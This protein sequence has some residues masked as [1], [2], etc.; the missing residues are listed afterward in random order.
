M[1]DTQNLTGTIAAF[2]DN[3]DDARQAVE[4]LRDA[5][6]SSAHIGVA[7]R[8][9][10]GSRFTGTASTT[11]TSAGTR[12]KEKA[13]STWDKIKSWFSGDEPEPYENERPRGDLAGREVVDPDA[14]YGYGSSDLDGSFRSLDIPEER[15][16]YFSHRLGRGSDGAVVTVNAGTRRSEAEDIL[17]EYGGDLGA[18]ASTY[19]YGNTGYSGDIG[20]AG[21][22]AYSQAAGTETAGDI[23][24]ENYRNES[25]E[26]IQLL[27]EVLR[28]HK[29]R[30]NRGEVRIRKEVVS[31]NQTVQ[32]PVT[33][34]ELVIERRPG[35]QAAAPAGNIGESEIRVPL[36]EERASIDKSTV[37]REQVSVGKRPVEEVKDVTGE[38]RHEELV[39]DDE[40]RKDDPNRRV[41]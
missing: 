31:E 27:G 7:H 26:N 24:R 18:N 20:Y 22:T 9:A 13:E 28:V 41:A 36:S 19:D 14:A 4:A 40:T 29:D 25:P 33:R 8:G 15:S 17:T 38:V 23:A 12:T 11:T 37:V 32:V 35:N 3:S 1:A 30:V 16:R 10:Y 6:F 21:R 5:G 39:V 2:F 34:E